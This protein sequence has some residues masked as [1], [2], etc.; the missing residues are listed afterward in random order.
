[1]VD[2]KLALADL[3][4]ALRNTKQTDSL[5]PS[6][7]RILQTVTSFESVYLTR[8]D[9]ERGV[10]SIMHA[11]NSGSLS[12]PEGLE[13]PWSDTLCR[14]AIEQR[15]YETDDVSQCW[16]DSEA[17]SELGITS[18]VSRPVYVGEQQ[19][20]Y[21]TLCAASTEQQKPS[22]ATSQLFD[23]FTSLIAR[24]V[25]RDLM[26]ERLQ[27]EQTELRQ[28]AHTDPLTGL[29]NRRGLA[30]QVIELQKTVKRPLHVAYIDLDGFK[31]INDLYGHDEGDRFLIAIAQALISHLPTTAIVARIGGDE[32]AVV[33]EADSDDAQQSEVI[34]H[35]LLASLT[36]GRFRTLNRVIDYAGPSIGIVTAN[37]QN[38][39]LEDWLKL[40]DQAMYQI[41]NR[42]VSNS[43][44][45]YVIVNRF[46]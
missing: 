5:A 1:M 15:Q 40:A 11:I 29:W 31:A 12:I 38:R 23:I 37:E 46:L 25:E 30:S 24:Q 9:E 21:G 44:K 36:S 41:K 2:E 35:K 43:V 17:A 34:L 19:E 27:H 32:F 10:Q 13:V 26:I 45:S 7:L 22:E 39:R 20:L 42:D 16:G 4:E 14:R 3:A 18:Y 28:S 6:L 8:V 33:Q